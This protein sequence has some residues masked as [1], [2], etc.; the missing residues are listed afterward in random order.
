MF[1]V[2]ARPVTTSAS[3]RF[4]DVSCTTLKNNDRVEVKGSVQ[5][6]ALAASRVEKKS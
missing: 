4:D 2:G 3:T 6:G 5:N 1:T